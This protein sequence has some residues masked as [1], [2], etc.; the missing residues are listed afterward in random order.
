M[1]VQLKNFIP[2]LCLDSDLLTLA[3]GQG[4][5]V[6]DARNGTLDFISVRRAFDIVVATFDLELIVSIFC[7]RLLQSTA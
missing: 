2:S 3:S 4:V 7:S 5:N 1:T 6:Y